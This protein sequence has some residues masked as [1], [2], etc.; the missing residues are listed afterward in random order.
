[1][2]RGLRG[3][4]RFDCLLGVRGASERQQTERA[5][6]LDDARLAHRMIR[7]PQ[8]VQHRQR[9]IVRGRGVQIAR[10]REV[11]L[12]RADAGGRQDEHGDQSADPGRRRA[13]FHFFLKSTLKRAGVFTVIVAA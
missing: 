10:R 4:D 2:I 5:V 9:I 6:L 7:R 3:H 1:M 12:L 11:G 8:P 13:G